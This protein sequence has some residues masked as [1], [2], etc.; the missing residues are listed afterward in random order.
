[1][2]TLTLTLTLRLEY[3]QKDAKTKVSKLSVCHTKHI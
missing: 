1:M 2:L 3:S